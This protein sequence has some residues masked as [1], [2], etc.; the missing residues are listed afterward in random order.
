M[1]HIFYNRKYMRIAFKKDMSKFAR[2]NCIQKFVQQ[3]WL[4]PCNDETTDDATSL[5]KLVIFVEI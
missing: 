2:T 1:T 5:Q 4:K 3:T